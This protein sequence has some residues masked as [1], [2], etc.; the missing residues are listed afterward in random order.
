MSQDNKIY[1][2]L[3]KHGADFTNHLWFSPSD[4]EKMPEPVRIRHFVFQAVNYE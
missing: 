1:Q 2:E 4:L 3:L